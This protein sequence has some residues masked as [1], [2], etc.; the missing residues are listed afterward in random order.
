M[1]VSATLIAA[2]Q[3]AR[4][5]QARFQTAHIAPRQAATGPAAA[6]PPQAA[7][8]AAALEKHLFEPL[9][10]KQSVAP[11]AAAISSVP[12]NPGPATRPGSLLDIRI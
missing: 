8:F 4:E 12:A 1:Q 11:Q 3:A 7:N 9:P 10:L 2:Q 6:G 5:A